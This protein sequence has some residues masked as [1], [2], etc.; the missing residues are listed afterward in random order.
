MKII[1]QN[2]DLVELELVCKECGRKYQVDYN[3]VSTMPLWKFESCSK[4]CAL[5]YSKDK[6]L[7]LRKKIFND[8]KIQI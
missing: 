1:I 4:I 6:F 2:Q 5:V 8:K 3:D 7:T